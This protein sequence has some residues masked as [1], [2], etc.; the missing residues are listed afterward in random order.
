MTTPTV[1]LEDFKGALGSWASGVTVV[2]TELDGL[3]YGITVSSFS[4]LSVD[5]LLVL[6]SLADTNQLPRLIER[7]GRFAIS[8]LASDQA[9]VSQYFAISGREPAPAF[10]PSIDV[11]RWVTGA[12]LIKGALAQL[13]CELH[14]ALP[15][16][17]HTITIGRVVAAR[18]NPEKQPLIYFR[19]GYRSLAE[20]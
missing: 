1:T 17:D 3:V 15:G 5:P 11:E 2:T 14:A 18:S 13:D 9:P 20:G 7:S 19:R 10:D 12:P 8:I 16:G 4:S 6:V